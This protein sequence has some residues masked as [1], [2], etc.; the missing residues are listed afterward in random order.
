MIC[1]PSS[2]LIRK[3]RFRENQSY[4]MRKPFNISF[5]LI[6]WVNAAFG[7]GL[8]DSLRQAIANAPDDT[9]KVWLIRDLYKIF[10]NENEPE[11]M[12]EMAELGLDLSRQLDYA[13]GIDYMIYYQATALDIAGRGNEAIPLY[14][15]GLALAQKT[16]NHSSAADYHINLG[17]AHFHH[18]DV[19]E[20]LFHYL[21]A[22]DIY[23]KL[24]EKEKLAK[25]LN[26]V[27]IIY[28]SQNK[29]DRA[30]EIYKEA[31]QIKKEMDDSLG[32]AVSLQNL[33]AVLNML[34][35]PSLA[36]ESMEGA[37]ALYRNL[38][39]EA[40][41]ASCY[42]TLGKIYLDNGRL[43]EG[44]SA[45]EQA[46]RFFEGHPDV[47]FSASTMHGL[48]RAA[49]LAN[50][51]GEAE[52]YLYKS[53]GIAREFGQKDIRLAVLNDLGEVLEKQGK[54][55]DALDVL[56][57]AYALRDSLTEEKRLSL[58]EEMQARF[59]VR[60]KEAD[61][62]ISQLELEQRTRQR[63]LFILGA[64]G[65]ALLAFFVFFSF[66]AR[67]KANKKIAGHKAEIQR[68]RIQ[69]LEQDKKLGA[70]KAM[71][72]GQEKERLRIANDLHDGLGGLLTSI[73]S[74]FNALHGASEKNQLIAKTNELIDTACGEVRRVSHNMMPRALAM[75]G[76]KGALEDLAQ[77]IRQQNIHCELETIGLEEN[78]PRAQSAMIYR[79]IQELTNNVLKHAGAKNLLLQLMLKNNQLRILVED[80]GDGF[81]VED[82][83]NKKGLGLSSVVSR[84]EFLHGKIDWDS[85]KGEGTTVN[86]L[87][88]IG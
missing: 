18:G 38:G 70:L 41:V 4:Q 58:L 25:V 37:I 86:I 69:Q 7:Q 51:F 76:L 79:I 88:P 87:I 12:I 83:F 53:L 61:L 5:L 82:A 15:A 75:S 78:M 81:G 65:L 67:M 11:K 47:N 33:G 49:Y 46:W 35:K 63:D 23:V 50:K 62:K 36:I 57:K 28:R 77:D 60:Q 71:F 55:A 20:A 6:F 32:M 52:K 27:A 68:Q 17:V 8:V 14:E 45:Y 21:H 34:E 80:D 64:A 48:G 10:Y 74:H 84:V 72:E 66:N 26:N 42:T 73:K 1:W 31:F 30:E 54:H 13:K 39:D 24:N 9:S 43:S 59:D 3:N 56:R 85:V 16:D 22:H 2:E 44:K 19:E 29:F 40:G